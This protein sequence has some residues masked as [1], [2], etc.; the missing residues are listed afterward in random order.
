MDVW[1]AILL[2]AFRVADFCSFLFSPLRNLGRLSQEPREGIVSLMQGHER[3]SV[4]YEYLSSVGWALAPPQRLTVRRI[5]TGKIAVMDWFDA[6]DGM[7]KGF[8]SHGRSWADC[9]GLHLVFVASDGY[10][11]LWPFLVLF[12]QFRGMSL[13]LFCDSCMGRQAAAG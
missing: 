12:D 1:T 7:L 3:G 5:G 9:E 4:R 6:K 13:V 11:R 8:P 10:G 2:A